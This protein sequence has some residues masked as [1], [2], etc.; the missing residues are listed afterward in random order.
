ME[1]ARSQQMALSEERWGDSD[2]EDD[3]AGD[4]RESR[5]TPGGEGEG[6]WAE[7]AGGAPGPPRPAGNR[8]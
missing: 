6:R 2:G 7:S 5:Q 1:A 4:S 8:P 3:Q